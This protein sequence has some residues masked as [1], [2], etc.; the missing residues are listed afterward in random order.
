M[1]KKMSN[2]ILRNKALVYFTFYFTSWTAK[3]IR[4]AMWQSPRWA[5]RTASRRFTSKHECRKWTLKLISASFLMLFCLACNFLPHNWQIGVNKGLTYYIATNAFY[6]TSHGAFQALLGS[7]DCTRKSYIPP[8]R[9]KF[10]LSESIVSKFGRT[11][12][13]QSFISVTHFVKFKNFYKK[14]LV[15]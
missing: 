3:A 11:F 2:F 9:G 4:G 8:C 1:M 14:K 7:L 15:K 5:R 10:A 12:I 13:F 6:L